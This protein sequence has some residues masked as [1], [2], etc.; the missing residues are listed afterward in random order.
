MQITLDLPDNLP[1][2][3][4]DVR[5][6]LASSIRTTAI[7]TKAFKCDRASFSSVIPHFISHQLQIKSALSGQFLGAL[8]FPPS[9]RII[10][11]VKDASG[12]MSLILLSLRCR[13]L[14]L[15]KDASGL[16]SMI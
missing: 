5:I 4:A 6:E 15:V 14:N 11:L 8:G 3:E 16:T 9:S 10:T 12:L 2:A 1:L 7:A 13:T